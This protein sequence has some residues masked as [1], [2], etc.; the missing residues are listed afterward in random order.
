MIEWCSKTVCRLGRC[1]RGA[2]CGLWL[3]YVVV[4]SISLVGAKSFP[5]A[6]VQVLADGEAARD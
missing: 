5:A 1:R 3:R 2:G 6:S 4:V